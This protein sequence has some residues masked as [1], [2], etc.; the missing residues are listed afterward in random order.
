GLGIII[1]S[2]TAFLV[3]QILDAYVFHRLRSFT[4]NKLIWLRATGSTLFSQ[5]I[6]SFVVVFIAFYIFGDWPINQVLAVGSV[7]YIYK[8]VVAILLTPLIYLAH[9][10]IDRFLGKEQSEELIEAAMQGS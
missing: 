4:N 2:L 7:N 5:L 9:Y 6:D 1:G 8:F 10:L 3:G